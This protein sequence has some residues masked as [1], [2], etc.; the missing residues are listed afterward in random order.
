M[1]DPVAW[2]RLVDRRKFAVAELGEVTLDPFFDMIAGG[3]ADLVPGHDAVPCLSMSVETGPQF[4][5]Q[6]GPPCERAQAVALAPAKL[7]GVA[8]PGRAREG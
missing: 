2:A 5:I 3:P 7:V 1:C 6:K 4:F 8:Q